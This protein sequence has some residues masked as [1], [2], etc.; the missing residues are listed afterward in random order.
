MSEAGKL[1]FE[2]D[3]SSF[4]AAKLAVIGVGGAGGNAVGSMVEQDVT[5]VTLMVANTDVQ[6][7]ERSKAPIHLQLGEALTRGLGAGGNP[8]VGQNAAE[9]SLTTIEDTL[10]D[11][12][13]L[14]VTA[15]MGGGTGTG[16]APVI[17]AKARE[18]GILTVGVV[19]RPFRFEGRS[20]ELV[21]DQGVEAMLQS[22]NTL[23]VIPNQKLLELDDDDLTMIE[24]FRKADDVLVGAVR[25]I[26]DLITTSGY[27]NVDFADVKTIMMNMGMAIMGSGASSGPERAIEAARQAVSS[28]LLDNLSIKGAKGVLVNVTGSSNL[29]LREVD[30]AV[31][32]IQES[33]DPKATFIFGYVV[34]ES[35]G[36]MVKVTVVA[37]GFA[38]E[39]GE[40]A[41][42]SD[43]RRRFQENFDV[44]ARLRRP[45]REEAAPNVARR[46]E[47]TIEAAPVAMAMAPSA[48]PSA[49]DAK[50]T[51]P[52]GSDLPLFGESAS[53]RFMGIEL[54]EEE[55][56]IP[57]FRRREAP[58]AKKSESVY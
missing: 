55:F 3:N 30:E 58:R 6:V 12:D 24:A 37:T 48:A 5:N 46:A 57:S 36:D 28:P 19:T 49:L 9:E 25:G 16:A 33:A 8:V 41:E 17:A 45:K 31:S 10:Q 20:R 38:D 42:R 54:A 14:F 18:M 53:R 26:S 13:M 34:D 7:L 27:V 43:R 2:F 23:V 51:G 47:P 29:G 22:V 40:R 52:L 15:G 39:D 50:P 11:V 56:S 35:L 21:A 1:K 4:R 44:P 32:Y